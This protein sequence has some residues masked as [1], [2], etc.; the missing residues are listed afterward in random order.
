V[1]N[2][3]CE[4][5][6][7]V[8]LRAA[9][10]QRPAVADL[11]RVVVIG[12]NGAVGRLLAGLL[13]DRGCAV[14]IA[15]CAPA[16]HPGV[17]ALGPYLAVDARERSDQLDELLADASCAL[18]VL[19][20]EVALAALPHVLAALPRDALLAD[21]LSVKT[22]FVQTARATAPGRVELLSLNPMFA[23]SLGF[24]GQSV[25]A[26][27]AVRGPRS[28][29]L[30]TLLRERASVV[31]VADEHEHDRMTAAL[32]AA[33]HASVL[34]F[35]LAL[36]ELDAD[37]EQLLPLAPPPFIALLALLARIASGSPAT[38][39]DIQRTNPHAAAARDALAA[40][41]A[42]L[43]A[44]AGDPDPQ[45]LTALLGDVAALLGP[46]RAVL[47]ERAAALLAQLKL[48]D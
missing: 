26:V 1:G 15:D 11:A 28:D 18:I 29:A 10:E 42:Q 33:T 39:G 34:G 2:V 32:Q 7:K 17:R 43:D 21:T 8:G 4:H 13:A 9:D 3:F 44:A 36:R 37:V 46:D 24:A 6:G 41:L 14:V 48:P 30:L 38:Y 5:R 40:G 20:E 31:V 19:P 27:E 12:G 16:P 47:A 35:G 23:P 25:L 22:P 45:R